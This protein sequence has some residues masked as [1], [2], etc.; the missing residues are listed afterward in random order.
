MHVIRALQAPRPCVEGARREAGRERQH[1][2]LVHRLH[3]PPR[4]LQQSRGDERM[5]IDGVHSC[6]QHNGMMGDGRKMNFHLSS[7]G[8]S[9]DSYASVE[10]LSTRLNITSWLHTSG[11][12][13]PYDQGHSQQR[14]VQDLPG[15]ARRQQLAH[16]HQGCSFRAS[17]RIELVSKCVQ[18][19]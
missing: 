9:L 13:L 11:Q 14:S 19:I 17:H 12:G 10:T 3:G 1:Q 6:M 16:I 5:Q 7:S 2:D 4:C 15:A 18:I 8:D